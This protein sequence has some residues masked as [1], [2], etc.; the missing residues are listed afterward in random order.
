MS[1]WHY[2]ER[3]WRKGVGAVPLDDRL[4]RFGDGCFET[5][6]VEAG[7]PLFVRAHLARLSQS[8]RRLRLSREL[9]ATAEHCLSLLPSHGGVYALR[10]FVSAGRGGG[11]S[12]RPSGPLLYAT[13]AP[14]ADAPRRRLS[15]HTYVRAD[16]ALCDLKLPRYTEAILAF[17]RCDDVLACDARGRVLESSTGNLFAVLGGR[18]V[19]PPADGRILHGVTRDVLLRTLAIAER[20]LM[21]EALT[22]A[23]AVFLTS[24]LRG[25][26]RVGR[27][28]GRPVRSTERGE[29]LTREVVLAY[30]EAVRM[31]GR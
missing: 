29:T 28:D 13:L 16:L 31:D 8:L 5:L 9:L 22:R 7:K 19:T 25:I 24:S 30:R 2:E 20:P 1:A 14:Y 11:L 4:F 10:L 15:V 12:T 18:L 21:R 3:R 17:S 23:E 26:A 27:I 6:R